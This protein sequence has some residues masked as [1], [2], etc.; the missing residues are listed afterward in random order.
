MPGDS[1]VL[2][3]REFLLDEVTGYDPVADTTIRL[4]FS[5]E[6]IRFSAG[7]NSHMGSYSVENGV[8][9]AGAFGATTM[10]CTQA[11]MTQDAWLADFLSSDPALAL[12]GDTLTLTGESATLVLLDSEVA[13]PDRP[14]T[15]QTWTID[16]IITGEVVMSVAQPLTPTVTFGTDGSL[17]I[18]TGCNVGEGSYEVT[19]TELTFGDITYDEGTCAD[20]ETAAFASQIQQVFVGSA[21]YSIDEARLVIEGPEL[22][23]YAQSAR[24]GL[25]ASQLEKTM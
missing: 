23:V 12:E 16:S 10:G 24:D 18:E 13:N 6:E 1:A 21:T 7:C 25:E 2:A 8:L 22:G 3:D 17:T 20:A 15:G 4:G 14:L 19:E 9:V 11:L 5:A